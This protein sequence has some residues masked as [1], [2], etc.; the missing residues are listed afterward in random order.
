MKKFLFGTVLCALVALFAS[1][2]SNYP[3]GLA[4][5]ELKLPVTTGTAKG[6]W[7]KIGVAPSVSYL[8]LIATGDSSIKAACENGDIT[9]IVYI[10]WEVK[11]IL[12]LIGDYKLVV[13][14]N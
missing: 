7:T 14:G 1:C 8:S 3:Q 12:G 5:T 9:E 2:A 4:Y 10:D 11:N 6:K 13:Y